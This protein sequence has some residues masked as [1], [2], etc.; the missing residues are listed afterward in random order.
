MHIRCHDSND[1]ISH[2][3]IPRGQ[4]GVAILHSKRL[5]D[6][7]TKLNVGNERIIALELNV[8]QKYCIVNA[9]MPTNKKDTDFSYREC[10][11]VLH[12]IISRYESS[13][14]IVVCGDMNGT[15]LL[16]R[17]NKHDIMLKDFVK[18]HMLSMGNNESL[19]PT[20]Y[21]FNGTD[22]S[23]IDYILTSDVKLIQDYAICQKSAVNVSSH[24]PVKSVL[25]ISSKL[26]GLDR[27]EKQVQGKPRKVYSWNKI[28]QEQFMQHVNQKLSQCDWESTESSVNSI[29][30]CLK[31]AAD[32]AVPSKTVKFKGPKKPV[33]SEVLTRLKR[34]KES[35]KKWDNAGKPRTGQLFIENKLAKRE[36]RSQQRIE[37]AIRRKSFYESVME[38]PRVQNSINSLKE[39]EQRLS[40]KQHVFK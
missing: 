26:S 38:I 2:F 34:L 37:E 9:Y 20:F 29:T 10:L 3:S 33:S 21:H 1:P 22:T 16:T 11:D 32:H 18:E 12:D 24:V 6:K 14:K 27:H 13:H 31:S 23:Q 36:L 19:E 15:L 39:V 4:S 7:I 5:S 17:N 8:G 25:R 28:D 40:P 35:Y 30:S